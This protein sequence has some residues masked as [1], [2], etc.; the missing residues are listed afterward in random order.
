[1]ESREIIR[2]NKIMEGK[3]SE[4]VNS[5]FE[6]PWWLDAV[7]PGMW[8][9]IFVKED[10][11][12]V[13]RWPLIEVS[14]GL[15]MPKLTQTLGIWISD[16]ILRNDIYHNH[17]KRI[18]S[19]LLNQLP[20]N[21]GINICLD[22]K[23]NYFLPMHWNHFN[24]IPHVSYR[25]N[26]LIDLEGIYDNFARIVKDNLKRTGKKINVKSIDDIELLLKLLIKTFSRQ[27]MKNPWPEELIRNIYNASKVHNACKLLYAYDSEGNL[28]SGNLFVFDKKVCY[29]LISATD[30]KY[31]SS[32]ATTLLIW[33]GIK[34]ASTVSAAFDFEGSMVE[35][36]ENFIR[37]FG[38]KQIVYYQIQKDRSGLINRK[39]LQFKK[40]VKK[41]I[42]S[43]I[44]YDNWYRDPE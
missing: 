36:I 6:Q 15:G 7:A 38:G 34:Y 1:M 11:K 4:Y 25:F 41:I 17:R 30:P 20:V 39:F 12:I 14:G 40:Q 26:D 33:E 19:S 37:Q 2:E 9:E 31:R 24:I 13:A 43:L 16:E 22:T 10:D 42:K 21:V 23:M 29:Y 32:G 35:G 8:R 18:I 28:H 27:N 5:V 3:T 44:R